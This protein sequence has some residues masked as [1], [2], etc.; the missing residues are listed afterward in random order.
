M[1]VQNQELRSELLSTP[2]QLDALSNKN[3]RK[4]GT[5]L[6]TIRSKRSSPGKS[7]LSNTL[8]HKAFSN[9][10]DG[11]PPSPRLEDIED[12]DGKEMN[13]ED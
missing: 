6:N 8:R 7:A 3:N 4:S 2:L 13:I 11:I 9:L 10:K 12:E 1:N 5:A